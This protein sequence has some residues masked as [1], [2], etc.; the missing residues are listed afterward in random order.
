MTLPSSKH[1]LRWVQHYETFECLVVRVRGPVHTLRAGKSCA[2]WVTADVYLPD[3][4]KEKAWLDFN[5]DGTYP[6]EVPINWNR[7][8]LA[9][10]LASG[11]L[12]WDVREIA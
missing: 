9:A 7:R 8:S 4:Y 5:P 2:S 12:E 11:D 10:F 1:G 3:Q 6:V